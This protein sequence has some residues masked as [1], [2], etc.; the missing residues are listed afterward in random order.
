MPRPLALALALGLTAFAAGCS[1]DPATS[2]LA[3]GSEAMVRA[4]EPDPKRPPVP[5]IVVFGD[6]TTPAD[7]VEPDGVKMKP[8]GPITTTILAGSKVRIVEDRQGPAIRAADK[9]YLADLDGETDRRWVKVKV[10]DG[11]GVNELGELPRNAL[12]PLP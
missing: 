8:Q 12:R 2:R 9:P 10:L 6:Q 1:G 3:E 11:R 4:P 5:T 7:I